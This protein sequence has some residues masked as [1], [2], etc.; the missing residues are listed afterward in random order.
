[1]VAGAGSKYK[2]ARELGITIMTEDEWIE[3][4]N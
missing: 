2:K 4:L 1:M 3:F